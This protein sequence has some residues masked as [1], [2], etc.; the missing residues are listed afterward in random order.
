MY[1]TAHSFRRPK[2]PETGQGVLRS[3]PY[4]AAFENLFD[5]FYLYLLFVFIICIFVQTQGL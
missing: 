4:I 1:L 3:F 5:N 2:R